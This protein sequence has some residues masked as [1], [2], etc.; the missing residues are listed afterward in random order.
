MLTRLESLNP[1]WVCDDFPSPTPIASAPYVPGILLHD[2][3]DKFSYQSALE[4]NAK[5]ALNSGK[6]ARA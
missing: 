5:E 3:V 6:K 1:G 4:G 2:T